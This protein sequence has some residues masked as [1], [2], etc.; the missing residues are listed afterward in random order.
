M[1]SI[2]SEVIPLDEISY[3]LTSTQAIQRACYVQILTLWGGAWDSA[4]L[5]APKQ[6]H[7]AGV[8]T[9]VNGK[10]LAARQTGHALV[11]A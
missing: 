7:A 10:V 5:T 4:F 11:H 3:T 9:T 8:W 6:C 1:G 2:Y